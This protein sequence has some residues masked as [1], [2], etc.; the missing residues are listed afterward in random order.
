MYKMIEIDGSHGEG[1]RQ[2][3]K[4]ALALSTITGKGF[5]AVKIR[6]GREKSGLKDLQ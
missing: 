2:I 6:A 3:I 5:K 4:T 1:G